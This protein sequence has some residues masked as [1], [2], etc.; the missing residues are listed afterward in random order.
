MGRPTGV[1]SAV[2]AASDNLLL[3]SWRINADGEVRRGGD[4]SPNQA[5]GVGLVRLGIDTQ[6][7]DAPILTCVQTEANE[8]QLITWD[9]QPEHG[10]LT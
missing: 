4:S 5:G 6:Q 8:L 9:N 1:V 3:I 7:S 10:V 2:K